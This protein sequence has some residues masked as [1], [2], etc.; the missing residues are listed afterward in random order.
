VFNVRTE[1]IG[2]TCVVAPE[3]EL[4]LSTAHQLGAAIAFA[5]TR[6]TRVVLD[7][8]QLTFVDSSGISVI[9]KLKRHLAVEGITFGVV[10]GTPVVQ[11]AFALSR[12]EALMPWTNP[13]RAAA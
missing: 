9:I 7:L 1:Q 4:D 6:A 11:R 5:A 12:V 2:D 8:R 13:P 3:G 10:K